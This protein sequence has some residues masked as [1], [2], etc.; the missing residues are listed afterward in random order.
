MAQ[1]SHPELGGTG[2]WMQG[3]MVMIGDMFNHSL[4]ARVAALCQDLAQHIQ[5]QAPSSSP[6]NRSFFQPIESAAWWPPELGRPT[7][8][9]K[10]NDLDYA[11]F[12]PLNRLAI[13]QGNVSIVYDTTGYQI[14]GFGQQQ[15]TGLQGLYLTSP[16][17]MIAVMSLPIVR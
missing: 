17:G 8:Q 16:Q 7:A 14:T 15:T 10:Q 2:Q 13:R 11:Y 5:T 4:K 3:G 6:Q 1:F 9:G 12:A